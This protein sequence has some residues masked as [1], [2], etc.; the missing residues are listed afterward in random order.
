MDV[1]TNIAAQHLNCDLLACLEYK[2]WRAIGELY[3]LYMYIY[4]AW[5]VESDHN[6]KKKNATSMSIIERATATN[7]SDSAYIFEQV[8]YKIKELHYSPSYTFLYD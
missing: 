3:L 6:C 8:N 4:I 5:N 7:H 2:K 1:V